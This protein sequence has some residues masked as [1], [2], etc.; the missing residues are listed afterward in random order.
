MADGT[1][2][3]GMIPKLETCIAAIEDGVEAAVILDGRVPHALLLELFTN[4]RRRHADPQR[5]RGE[6]D[7]EGEGRGGSCPRPRPYRHLGVRSRQHALSRLLP[8]VR[9]GRPADGRVH[10]RLPQDRSRRGEGAAETLLPRIRDHLERSHGQSRLSARAV[11]GACA[12]ARPFAGPARPRPRPG[13]GEAAR[14]QAHLHQRLGAPRRERDGSAR[15]RPALRRRLRH[16][17]RRLLPRNRGR[18]PMPRWSTV[19]GSSRGARR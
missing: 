8:A 13:A 3:G 14:A 15:R 18:K 7:D 17:R 16:R 10:L 6:G 11:P 5:V 4:A 19:T 1:I 9:S 12:Q 2:S